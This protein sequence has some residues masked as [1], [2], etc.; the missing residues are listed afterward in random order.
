MPS[1]DV[2]GERCLVIGKFSIVALVRTPWREVAGALQ[3][4]Q[5]CQIHTVWVSP[6]QQLGFLLTL[7]PWNLISV[8][9]SRENSLRRWGPHHSLA[10]VS[11]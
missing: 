3:G 6:E 7:T 10:E 11:E 1:E 8:G 2:W 9:I 5:H 4:Q